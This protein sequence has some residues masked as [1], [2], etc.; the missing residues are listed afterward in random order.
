MSYLVAY[1]I[2]ENRIRNKLSR[3]LEK[4]GVRLQKSVFVVKI[5]RHTLKKFLAGVK[6]ITGPGEQ[7]AV[8][9]LCSGCERSAVQLNDNQAHEFI[10]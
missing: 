3:Y 2:A 1:D 4:F 9:R 10:F 5:E 6:R 7:V 8:F